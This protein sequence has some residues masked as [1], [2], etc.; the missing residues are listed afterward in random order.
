M[1]ERIR[2]AHEWKCALVPCFLL[3]GCPS[4]SSLTH[5]ARPETFCTT[6]PVLRQLFPTAHWETQVHNL[7]KVF[8]DLKWQHPV[9]RSTAF[10]SRLYVRLGVG[11]RRPAGM[12]CRCSRP[13]M[14]PA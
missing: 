1:S 14:R 7:G 4:D 3:A 6:T 13:G 10:H 9:R 2:G 5:A 8:H 12:R 11:L